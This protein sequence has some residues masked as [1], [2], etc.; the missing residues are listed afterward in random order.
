MKVLVC[1]AAPRKRTGEPGW[2][3]YGAIRRDLEKLPS[4]IIVIEG[5]AAGADLIARRMAE[6]LGLTV[7][8]DPAKWHIYGRS[9]GPIRNKQMLD[10]GKPDLVLAFHANIMDSKGTANMILQATKRGI[11]VRVFEK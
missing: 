6:E 8:P 2:T 7:E 10:E 9:A 5:E 1:G 4:N 3:D 11:E